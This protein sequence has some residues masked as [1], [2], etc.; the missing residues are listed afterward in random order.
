[1]IKKLTR[2][3]LK[4]KILRTLQSS[5]GF[6][7]SRPITSN[8][9]SIWYALF[10]SFSLNL[11]QTDHNQVGLGAQRDKNIVFKYFLLLA[12]V[13]G[14]KLSNWGAG[15]TR[16]WPT[17]KS[18]KG[19]SGGGGNDEQG[20]WWETGISIWTGRYMSLPGIFLGYFLVII[21]LEPVR[22]VVLYN[23]LKKEWGY[24]IM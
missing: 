18:E 13:M 4:Q 20:G 8:L 19:S 7:L 24:S 22:S 10:T 14:V 3:C 17:Q 16:M 1:M 15:L 21:P 6:D 12:G 11:V 9:Y 23:K 2:Q 5:G